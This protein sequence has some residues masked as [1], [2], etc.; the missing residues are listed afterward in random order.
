MRLIRRFVR[1]LIVNSDCAL[2]IGGAPDRLFKKKCH[3]S[4]TRF[5]FFHARACL[6]SKPLC[7]SIVPLAVFDRGLLVTRGPPEITVNGHGPALKQFQSI[8][9]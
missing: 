8:I 1:E 4:R 2:Q 7:L 5:A 3:L 9:E 6:L